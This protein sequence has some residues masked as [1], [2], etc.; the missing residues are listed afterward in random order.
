MILNQ[1]VK[2]WKRSS[3]SKDVGCGWRGLGGG[4]EWWDLWLG[5]V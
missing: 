4:D 5:G 3:G 2:G 1:N